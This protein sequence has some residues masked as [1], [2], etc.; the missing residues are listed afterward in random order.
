MTCGEGVQQRT[1]VCSA[2]ND[3]CTSPMPSSER[4]CDTGSPCPEWQ[5]APWSQV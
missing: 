4:T 1:V 2:E 5:S 3:D